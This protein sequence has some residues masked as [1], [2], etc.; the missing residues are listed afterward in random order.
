MQYENIYIYS[1]LEVSLIYCIVP[2]AEEKLETCHMERG[3]C[4][5]AKSTI[6]VTSSSQ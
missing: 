2:K 4:P 3:I 1:A 6:K 5:I